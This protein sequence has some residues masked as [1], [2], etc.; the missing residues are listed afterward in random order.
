MEQN[1]Q[2][3]WTDHLHVTISDDRM[4]AYI[5]IHINDS[6]SGSIPL[7]TA[8]GMEHWL[9]NKGIR[10]GLQTVVISAIATTPFQYRGQ[11]V[12]IATGIPPVLGKDAVVEVLSGD[13]RTVRPRLLADD[14]VD[15]FHITDICSVRAGTTI[16]K[17]I[18]P[19]P[20]RDGQD[21]F[22][23]ILPHPHPKDAQL[24]FGENVKIA[25]DGQ[26]ILA[27]ADGHLV[28]IPTKN[29]LHVFSTYTVEGNV[30]F[31]IGNIKFLGNV[32]IKGSVLDG[33]RIEA[34]G[35]IQIDGSV[36]AASVHAGRDVHILGGIQSRGKGVVQA[37]RNVRTRFVQTGKVIAGMDC[38]IQDSIMHSDVTAM[39]D[40]I[41]FEKK[42]VIVGGS[43]NAG[44]RIVAGTLGS[45]MAT[46]TQL[47]VGVRPDLRAERLQIERE[48]K[49]LQ[50]T[51]V[52]SLQA[53][54]IFHASVQMGKPL[55][56]EKEQLK[57]SVEKTLEFVEQQIV[58]KQERQTEIDRQL[59]LSGKSYVVG[60]ERTHPGVKIGIDN[61]LYHVQDERT[62]PTRYF[63]K[64]ET[65]TPETYDVSTINHRQRL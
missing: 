38:L 16:A 43:V 42:G 4:H 1:E 6:E 31:S 49:E 54:S 65:I 45:P 18:P 15:F 40:V 33:F 8:R 20:G 27:A 13:A 63:V 64:N 46:V 23:R 2:K 62:Q 3:W 19:I 59:V 21:V 57:H 37:G 48:L 53:I 26:S 29:Q 58:I 56:P 32:H 9:E 50:N 12:E 24:P 39:R 36:A 25:D 17:K 60:E 28:Y 51:R 22:G 44:E 55:S 7:L 47:T 5:Q 34:E 11:S 35:D 10:F 41:V 30:D 61:Y 14:R 52:K